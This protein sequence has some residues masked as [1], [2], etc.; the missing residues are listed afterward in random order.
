MRLGHESL[1]KQLL[2]TWTFIDLKDK[3]GDTALIFSVKKERSNIT[4]ILLQRG[5]SIN[6]QNTSGVTPL[7]CAVKVQNKDLISLLFESGASPDIQDNYGDT[8]LIKAVN[9]DDVGLVSFLLDRGSSPIIENEDGFSAYQSIS[10]TENGRMLRQIFITRF[11]SIVY[12]YKD[13]TNRI[14]LAHA[15]E[16][17]GISEAILYRKPVTRSAGKFPLPKILSIDLEGCFLENI[18]ENM[19]LNHSGSR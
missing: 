8:A 1:V 15:I 10:N 2:D 9:R 11:P 4:K 17:E 19:L 7:I 16:A 18:L 14:M 5:A 13:K 3:E 6:A 12:Y